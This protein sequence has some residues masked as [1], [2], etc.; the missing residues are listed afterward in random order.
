[1][2]AQSQEQQDA[3]A[4]GAGD[5]MGWRRRYRVNIRAKRRVGKS[6]VY[7]VLHFLLKLE[8][9]L[10]SSSSSSCSSSLIQSY[11]DPF[12]LRDDSLDAVFSTVLA[13]CEYLE[14]N[15]PTAS[16][17]DHIDASSLPSTPDPSSFVSD[18]LTSRARKWTPNDI[19]IAKKLLSSGPQ[20]LLSLIG[21]H[22]TTGLLL[23]CNSAEVGQP[24]ITG[25]AKRYT[26]R[27]IRVVSDPAN[28]DTA[29][30][31]HLV[32]ENVDHAPEMDQDDDEDRA[33]LSAV[34]EPTPADEP[35]QVVA[36]PPGPPTK[37]RGRGFPS[38]VSTQL[39]EELGNLAVSRLL[40]RA[41]SG[42]AR[43]E[44]G[45]TMLDD[46]HVKFC[47]DHGHDLV[48]LPVTQ[49]AAE[50]RCEFFSRAFLSS[51]KSKKVSTESPNEGIPPFVLS[52]PDFA[53][54]SLGTSEAD[55]IDEGSQAATLRALSSCHFNTTSTEAWP[56]SWKT[57]AT[58]RSLT[59][60]EAVRRIIFDHSLPIAVIQHDES[61]DCRSI[62]SSEQSDKRHGPSDRKF[63][64]LDLIQD[65]SLS[66]P[67]S[68]G[69][70]LCPDQI[71]SALA[72]DS[73]VHLVSQSSKIPQS[74]SFKRITERFSILN[75]NLDIRHLRRD[76]A[77][78]P[79]LDTAEIEL[80]CAFE[81]LKVGTVA[82]RSQMEKNLRKTE[83]IKN[84]FET[85]PKPPQTLDRSVLRR[86]G[87]ALMQNVQSVMV[88]EEQSERRDMLRLK[89]QRLLQAAFRDPEIRVQLQGSAVN[90]L[91]TKTSDVDMILDIPP[92]SNVPTHVARNVYLLCLHLKNGGMTNVTP[93][94][95]AKIPLCRFKDP[96]LGLSVDLN[97]GLSIIG[98][99]NSHLLRTYCDL[100]VDENDSA[101]PSITRSLMMA[102]K[103]WTQKRC[104][105]EPG[106]GMPSS[107]AWALMVI[108]Y[109]QSL[110]VIPSLQVLAQSR[111]ERQYMFARTERNGKASSSVNGA[112]AA[113]VYASP[114]VDPASGK[115]K[116]GAERKRDVARRKV[117]A[118]IRGNDVAIAYL[119]AAAAAGPSADPVDADSEVREETRL[120]DVTRHYFSGNE[121]ADPPEG[122]AAWDVTFAEAGSPELESWLKAE[123]EKHRKG[124]PTP[125]E[126]T[127]DETTEDF[128]VKLGGHFYGFLRHFGWCYEFASTVVVSP[129]LGTL[130]A[131][132]DPVLS[133]N[134]CFLL[135]EDPF[136][137]DRNTA[138]M[139]GNKSQMEYLRSQLRVGALEWR[140]YV[141]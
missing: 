115:A 111:P 96:V 22:V 137:L 76:D 41:S 10:S 39:L 114:S 26:F 73:F 50:V 19:A 12:S 122:M 65:K 117:D 87:A 89:V 13:V 7:L 86:W 139:V 34:V 4:A 109:L 130:T 5:G 110:G 136:Q 99:Q 46:V 52:H 132:R 113:I 15:H 123:R 116:S 108:A 35:P 58:V 1:M 53:L 43:E 62:C 31:T 69:L 37:Y 49:L 131:V 59:S 33:E 36:S 20:S 98:V 120:G 24:S 14:R 81:K 118:A 47:A 140:A 107:Y 127:A 80:I 85:E 21:Q 38:T 8:Q 133:T 128:H 74:P 66:Y 16:G 71:D 135:V 57:W 32:L 11:S 54:E 55:A 95:S 103:Q 125:T 42:G 119:T 102:V 129:R 141:N 121:A 9:R 77:P 138:C 27:R 67:W 112:D 105:N 63:Y 68:V 94:P 90:G 6:I 48:L 51:E 82:R 64:S 83:D 79:E 23:P 126:R 25:V 75:V 106:R 101:Q 61:E 84:P 70:S 17:G 44:G 30:T 93:I 72:I 60:K 100:N 104:L 97:I 29:G 56:A 3:A 88:T 28:E 134:G 2:A 91:G 78:S 124:S 45:E 92:T 40:L 18:D